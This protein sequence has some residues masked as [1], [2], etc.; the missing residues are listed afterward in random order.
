ML[1]IPLSPISLCVCLPWQPYAV[2]VKRN[3]LLLAKP[4]LMLSG[5]PLPTRARGRPDATPDFFL[6]NRPRAGSGGCFPLHYDNPGPPNKRALTCL[7]YLNPDWKDGDGGELCLTPFLGKEKVIAPLLDRMVSRRKRCIFMHS[8]D[9]HRCSVGI[10]TGLASLTN[11]R[12]GSTGLAALAYRRTWG[13]REENLRFSITT[14]IDAIPTTTA[15]TISVLDTETLRV[16]SA[17]KFLQ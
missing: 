5:F 14:I 1:L 2:S 16:I 10:C 13:R 7:L 6:N 12:S 3:I 11:R 8:R 4:V 17:R 9:V 15:S